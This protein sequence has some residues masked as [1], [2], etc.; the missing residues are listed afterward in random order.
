[1]AAVAIEYEGMGDMK[2]IYKFILCIM[3]IGLLTISVSAAS[4]SCGDNAVWEYNVSTKTLTISGTGDMKDYED[5]GNVSPWHDFCTDIQKIIV[6]EG[7]TALGN[8]SFQ[9]CLG[10]KEINLPE[11]LKRIGE[12]ALG[13]SGITEIYIPENVEYIGEGAFAASDKLQKIEVADGNKSYCIDEYG[14]LFDIEMTKIIQYPVASETSTYIVPHGVVGIMREAFRNARNLQEINFPNTLNWID[15]AAF[16]YCTGLTEIHIPKSVEYIFNFAFSECSNL[17]DVYFYGDVTY[18][19]FPEQSDPYPPEYSLFVYVFTHTENIYYPYKSNGWN[20]LDKSYYGEKNLF[21]YFDDFSSEIESLA[22]KRYVQTSLQTYGYDYIPDEGFAFSD[23]TTAS[24]PYLEFTDSSNGTA[25]LWNTF[26]DYFVDF[27]YTVTGNTITICAANGD[28]FGGTEKIVMSFDAENGHLE[29]ID[30]NMSSNRSL[31]MTGCND[32]FVYDSSV[33]AT[34]TEEKEAA[35]DEIEANPNINVNTSGNISINTEEIELY[36]GESKTYMVTV[37][38]DNIT[39]TTEFTD[40]VNTVWGE[41]DGNSIPLTFTALKDGPTCKLAV[42][43]EEEPS[44]KVYV[45]VNIIDRNQDNEKKT[46]AAEPEFDV[47]PAA[48]PASGTAL[49]NGSVL[50]AGELIGAAT[51]W[52]GTEDGGRI[53]AFDGNVDTFFDPETAYVDWCGIDAGEE[54]ILTKIVIHP[55]DSWLD[56][57]KGATIEASNDPEFKDSVELFFSTQEASKFAYI[58]CTSA[59]EESENTGYRYFRYINYMNHGDVAEVELYGYAKD[60]SNPKYLSSVDEKAEDKAKAE[61]EAQAKAEA[62]AQA[63]A[64]QQSEDTTD[65]DTPIWSAV[66][67]FENTP[68]TEAETITVPKD[69]DVTFETIE[70]M[71]E[72]KGIRTPEQLDAVRYD[73]SGKYILLNDIDMAEWGNWEPIGKRTLPFTGIFDGNGYCIQNL[74]L[75]F[76]NVEKK[77]NP[78]I[79]YCGL[80]AT[81]NKADIRN[82]YLENAVYDVTSRSPVIGGIV[83]GASEYSLITNCH[84]NGVIRCNSEYYSP[85][86]GGIAGSAGYVTTIEFCTSEGSIEVSSYMTPHVGGIVGYCSGVE[87]DNH[88]VNSI[89]Q[90]CSSNCHM[91]SKE[92]NNSAWFGGIVGWVSMGEIHDCYFTGKI[93][94][95][96]ESSC[97]GGI[98]GVLNGSVSNCYSIGEIINDTYQRIIGGI[99]GSRNR[100]FAENP[101]VTNCYIPVGLYEQEIGEDDFKTEDTAIRSISDTEMKEPN[102]YTDWNFDSVWMIDSAVNNGYPVL[103]QPV[104]EQIVIEPPLDIAK[105]IF[106]SLIILGTGLIIFSVVQ[107]ILNYAKNKTEFA[108]KNDSQVEVHIECKKC[109]HL[110]GHNAEFCGNCGTRLHDSNQS[111]KPMDKCPECGAVIE[112]GAMFCGN[113]GKRII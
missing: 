92:T 25:Y 94:I 58:N 39:V 93:T 2:Q 29:V 27:T 68:E 46:Q 73:L 47:F 101:S 104:V 78:T 1:V 61:A 99:I 59:I 28:T 48:Y 69:F 14:V 57:F 53:A 50:I 40:H 109:G 100:S 111:Q 108:E 55:R 43:L 67:T 91:V 107:I 3:F 18:G 51:G 26:T 35:K 23:P 75:D 24:P 22:E 79:D 88:D 9:G 105:I 74:T 96:D 16:S 98:V 85:E 86:I 97:V 6:N 36:V 44:N 42:Y 72:Y 31:G 64:E 63:K 13:F 106:V 32:I 8:C 7:I 15:I 76:V 89:V 11:S 10:L 102:T 113:C 45:K 41:W 65:N 66:V 60:G 82:V 70:S 19:Q 34:A 84:F 56:R 33:T 83:G 62:E 21:A 37:H 20:N 71:P 4:G 38:R 30:L 49:P 52:D 81:I 110:N 87:I 5:F 77:E 54:M 95:L 12:Y 90:Y 103:R 80:F 112:Q 17:K